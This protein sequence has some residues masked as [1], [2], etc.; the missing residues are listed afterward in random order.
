MLKKRLVLLAIFLLNITLVAEDQE[1]IDVLKQ[2]IK[3]LKQDFQNKLDILQKRI[4]E[5]E[6]QKSVKIEEKTDTKKIETLEKR[7]KELE[8]S[9][10]KK[11]NKKDGL[12][13]DVFW[14]NGL[15]IKD[16]DN[17]FN[18]TIGGRTYIDF[19]FIHEDK[20]IHNNLGNMEDYGEFRTA[21]LKLGG[22]IYKNFIFSLEFDFANPDIAFKDVYVGMKNLPFNGTLKIG[23]FKEPIS[24]QTLI[25]PNYITFMEPASV[26][27]FAPSRNLGVAYF[28]Y[29]N[30]KH[31]TYAFGLFRETGD[32]PP[33]IFDDSGSYAF[34][35]RITGLPFYQDNG[36]KLFHLGAAYSFRNP[37][38]DKLSFS[39]R[40]E[41]HADPKF[42]NTGS[43]EDVENE[44]RLG[45]EG[46]TVFGP[47]S[48]QSE[49]IYS[50]SRFEGGV[51]PSLQH[52]WGYYVSASFFITGEHRNYK[53]TGGVFSRVKINK[54]FLED[55][56]GIGAIELTA[57]YSKLNLNDNYRGGRIDNITIG[58]NWYIN[59]NMRVMINYIYSDL[60]GNSSLSNEY[61]K[62]D[63]HILMTRFQINI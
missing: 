13:L 24:L 56:N 2:Q 61:D 31:I 15:K 27:V 23:H 1:K 53:R 48:I 10:L 8:T 26:S 40:A 37:P 3:M 55:G 6:S 43:M 44:H 30:S 59:P 47:F 5:L 42:V 45:V 50:W 21:R 39:S 20:A 32:T 19:G 52:F 46:A 49:L 34:T 17:L 12:P 58:V 35:C 41:T 54:Y 38:S 51:N 57:R 16:K 14:K 22:T 28:G 11:E 60:N 62:V 4:N 33:E 25:S 9:T 29:D 63:A 18:I 36:S 7:V